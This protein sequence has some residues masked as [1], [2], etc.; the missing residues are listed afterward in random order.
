MA[1]RSG[2]SLASQM[3]SDL[4]DGIPSIYYVILIFRFLCTLLKGYIHP[5][6]FFQSPEIAAQNIFNFETLIPWEFQPQ[7][8]CRSIIPVFI[9]SG[10]SYFI[11]YFLSSFGLK[12]SSLLMLVTPRLMVC[13]QSIIVDF[14]VWKICKKLKIKVY[15]PL[16]TLST[17][18]VIL[19]FHTRTFSNTLESIIFASTLGIIVCSSWELRDYSIIKNI[20][21]GFLISLGIF[22][23]FTFL[24]LLIPMAFYVLYVTW[25]SLKEVILIGMSI[26]ISIIIFSI[27]FIGID[28]FYFGYLK[29]YLDSEPLSIQ[30]IFLLLS[31]PPLWIPQLRY[32]GNIIIT[33]IN[34]LIYNFDPENLKLHGIHNRLTHL[35]INSPLLF[36]PLYLLFPFVAFKLKME[37]EIKLMIGIILFY[38]LL[39]SQAIHQEPRFLLP[40]ITPLSILVGSSF[41]GKDSKRLW[42][43]L[44]ILFNIFMLILFGIFH[45]G[46]IISSLSEFQLM[47]S[48]SI[49]I[50]FYKTYMPP[51]YLLCSKGN[52]QIIDLAGS[53]FQ[54]LKE[55]LESTLNNS[56]D[57][58]YSRDTFICVPGTISLPSEF[59][60]SLTLWKS[61]GPHLSTENLPSQLSNLWESLQLNCYHFQMTGIR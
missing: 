28:S 39:L 14:S 56:T 57:S 3:V 5:D 34:S 1:K 23:R 16:I 45:Q 61:F 19:L 38:L 6:E 18:Y 43:G 49:N 58:N 32:E 40:L 48:N 30:N 44:W 2:K 31:N 17:S 9:N 46:G 41:F 7:F 35:L 13:L 21:L 20:I 10:I 60:Q 15:G 11:L 50:I 59:T 33:P 27:L 25:K 37:K 52:L 51:R 53:E 4:Q 47:N 54:S 55:T 26:G 12:I 42:K 24:F 22:T 36:G 29:I 8:P